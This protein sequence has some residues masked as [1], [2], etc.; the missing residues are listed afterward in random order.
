MRLPLAL[1]EV[2]DAIARAGSM[3]GAAEALGV[4]P[5]TISHQLKSLERQ[6]G[7][8]LFVRTTRSV[9]MTEAGRALSRGALPAFDQLAN[10]VQ[11]ARDVGG[12]PRGS[13][14][15]TLPEF[16]YTMALAPHIVSF[17]KAWP[18][19][20]LE[21]IM[22][23]ALVDLM[24]AGYHAGIRQGDRIEQDMVAIKLGEPLPLA[25]YG[26]HDYFERRGKPQSP[27][28]LLSHDCIRYRF[29]RSGRLAPWVFHDAGEPHTVDVSGGLIVSDLPALY[30]MI[31]DGLGLGYV[32]RDG[33]PEA[34]RRTGLASVLTDYLLPIPGLYLYYPREYRSMLP[35]RLFIDHMRGAFRVDDP[36]ALPAETLQRPASHAPQSSKA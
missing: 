6:M 9:L 32:F 27:A 11:E 8:A 2:F 31:A 19:I 20:E 34:L 10:A 29:H 7:T 13:L 23:D 15:I 14:R 33:P 24:E 21:L 1:L 25:V 16:A 36:G 28:D 18:E 22:T 5:S 4:T 12:S 17:R 30:Q 35:L 3:R 26:S